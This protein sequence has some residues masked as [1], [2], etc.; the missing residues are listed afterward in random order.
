[1][2]SPFTPLPS[3]EGLDLSLAKRVDLEPIRPLFFVPKLDNRPQDPIIETI[4]FGNAAPTRP[5]T[6]GRPT[7]G[8]PT[9][10]GIA[11]GFEKQAKRAP[12]QEKEQE[13]KLLSMWLR[14]ARKEDHGPAQVCLVLFDS[15][16]K[17]HLWNNR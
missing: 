6:S 14:A 2:D 15:L 4:N 3:L 8:A 13:G 12:K 5:S 11:N 17:F 10:N 1:M 9:T 16:S 7:N